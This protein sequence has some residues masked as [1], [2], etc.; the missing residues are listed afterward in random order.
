M[1]G[2]GQGGN[3]GLLLT[4]CWTCQFRTY[5]FTSW[6]TVLLEM[7][8]GS[9]LVKKF[10]A[11][12]GTWRFI[13]TF[14]SA[15]HLFLSWARSIQS[16]PPYPTSWR[17]IL[18]LSFHLRLGRPSALF[19]SATKTLYKP[20]LSPIHATCLAQLILL[21]LTTRPVLGEEYGSVLYHQ[22]NFLTGGA[23]IRVSILKDCAPW[24]VSNLRVCRH[25]ESECI[26]LM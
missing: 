3:G 6:S 2:S 10:P 17:S 22:R 13:T 23:T 21:D 16:M 18:I 4:R 20:L 9:Q 11:F 24:S 8:T 19:S 26:Q 14:T 15:R 12:Y 7:L 1:R 25:C 5:L